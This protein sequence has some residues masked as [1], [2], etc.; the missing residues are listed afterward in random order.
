MRNQPLWCSILLDWH[1]WFDGCRV[2]DEG[3][4]HGFDF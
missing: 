1:R 3:S 2:Y 4:D